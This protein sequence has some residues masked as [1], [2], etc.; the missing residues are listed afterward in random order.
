MSTVAENLTI[1]R[2]HYSS[3]ISQSKE[4]P[5]N[6]KAL[7]IAY[8]WAFK[9]YRNRLSPETV[10]VVRGLLGS[11]GSLTP[12]GI[13]SVV[14][15][16]QSREE[17]PP[18]PNPAGSL[19]HPGPDE[20]LALQQGPD[21]PQHVMSSHLQQ[22]KQQGVSMCPP[23][24]VTDHL[25]Q[26]VDEVQAARSPFSVHFSLEFSANSTT[27]DILSSADSSET[28][29]SITGFNNDVLPLSPSDET[30]SPKHFVPPSLSTTARGPIEHHCNA[31]IMANDTET[32]DGEMKRVGKCVQVNST[33][34][35]LSDPYNNIISITNPSVSS[36]QRDEGEQVDD[37]DVHR[38]DNA[39][40]P[41]EGRE[42][43]NPVMCFPTY[44][45]TQSS[46]KVQGWSILIS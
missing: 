42:C 14:L 17:F 6:E 9:R 28:I 32:R 21:E 11:S 23:S 35:P 46:R 13:H 27:H 43:N 4:L 41:Y 45:I 37:A 19:I 12:V 25:S 22:E 39:V 29:T 31:V 18:L 15:D 2:D 38:G 36:G 44:H 33:G 1:L 3:I 26:V 8:T 7:Q 30:C 10:T 5:L 16:L 34:S 24:G 40:S 20:S